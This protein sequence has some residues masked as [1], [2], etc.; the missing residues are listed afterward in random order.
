MGTRKCQYGDLCVKVGDPTSHNLTELGTFTQSLI[1]KEQKWG[2][3]Y[4][5]KFGRWLD[6]FI[7][8]FRR[9]FRDF[10]MWERVILSPKISNPEIP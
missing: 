7:Y 8:L 1:H 6:M 4:K 5:F 10:S 3:I 9:G 2:H